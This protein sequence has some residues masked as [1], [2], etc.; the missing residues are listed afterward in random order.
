M[1]IASDTLRIRGGEGRAS[2]GQCVK[3]TRARTNKKRKGKKPTESFGI[4]A[5]RPSPSGWKYLLVCRRDSVG[6]CD[7]LFGNETITKRYLRRVCSQITQREVECILHHPIERIL[8]HVF[9]LA[10]Q[11][12][13][14]KEKRRLQW[15]KQ[16]IRRRINIIRQNRDLRD[17]VDSVQSQWKDPGWGF[18]KGRLLYPSE[19]EMEC[20][21][22][23]FEEETGIGRSE[24]RINKDPSV[25]FVEEYVGSNNVTYRHNYFI[26]I[27]S[28]K[29]T[30][31]CDPDS[32]GQRFEISEVG[33]FP[34]DGAMRTIRHTDTTK[35]ACLSAAHEY[36]KHSRPK[37]LLI[38][39]DEVGMQQ[40]KIEQVKQRA[41]ALS[42][43]PTLCEVVVTTD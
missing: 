28:P 26:T 16:M 29:A 12:T 20:A 38:F 7:I 25:R 33:W 32:T 30:P 43:S 19:D 35:L 39:S 31:C 4:I 5:M 34:F 9:G 27:V 23:E 41:P 8:K 18:P 37:H 14:C 10:R 22:R 6:M 24:L 17:I 13:T 15:R 21:L 2:P 1:F 42:P 40:S 3:T 11:Y 36:M